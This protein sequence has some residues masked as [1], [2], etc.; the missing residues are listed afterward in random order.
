[1]GYHMLRS[2]NNF[3]C[4]VNFNIVCSIII[5]T[6]IYKDLRYFKTLKIIYP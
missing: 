2:K 4:L 3:E 5:T 6:F 1:M